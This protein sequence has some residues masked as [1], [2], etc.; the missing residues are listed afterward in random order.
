[1]PRI[2]EITYSK[3]QTLQIRAYEP[4]NVHFS[5]KAEVQYGEDMHLAYEA[6]K[7]IVDNEID[8]TVKMIQEPQRVARA[9]AKEVL[10]KDARAVKKE[11][12]P[13]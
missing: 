12:P 3:G 7:A 5:A 8:I 9:G 4:V 2:S 1:M 10:A 13:F 11:L 6:L